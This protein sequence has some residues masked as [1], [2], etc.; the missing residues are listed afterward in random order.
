MFGHGRSPR[1]LEWERVPVGKLVPLEAELFGSL[2]PPLRVWRCPWGAGEERG[3]ASNKLYF[4]LLSRAF[5]M[6][7]HMYVRR[8][9]VSEHSMAL[10]SLVSLWGPDCLL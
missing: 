4:R 9:C 3:H 10:E 2:L 7:P 8:A 6:N 1:R 5:E